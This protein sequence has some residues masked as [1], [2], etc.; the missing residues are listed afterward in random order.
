MRL[1]PADEI[2]VISRHVRA[3]ANLLALTLLVPNE[4]EVLHTTHHLL[5]ISHTSADNCAYRKA[6]PDRQ[7][8]AQLIAQYARS[9]V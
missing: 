9:D 1:L 4:S 7:H 8:D 6:C 5:M 3:F 2:S